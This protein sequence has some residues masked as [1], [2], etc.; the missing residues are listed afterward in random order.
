MPIWLTIL[1]QIMAMVISVGSFYLKIRSDQKAARM[2]Q[3]ERLETH[4]KELE[5]S[6]GQKLKNFETEHNMEVKSLRT[7]I[8]GAEERAE[9][10]DKLTNEKIER[11]QSKFITEIS[12][13]LGRLEGSVNSIGET[14]NLIQRHFIENR[15]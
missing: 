1:S 4:F 7:E 6:I 2:N 5:E 9:S 3:Q 12:G 14:L 10:K 13:R 8:K 15:K 11:L